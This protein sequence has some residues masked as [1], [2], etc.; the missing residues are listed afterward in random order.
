MQALALSPRPIEPVLT[1]V[2]A[3]VTASAALVPNTG[4]AS[5]AL[6]L[7]GKAW[8]FYVSRHRAATSNPWQHFSQDSVR[9]VFHVRR[10][11]RWPLGSL[12]LYR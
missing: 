11:Y 8:E 1:K 9:K 6:S 5:A 10:T 12:P 7:M 4:E 2:A 3:E